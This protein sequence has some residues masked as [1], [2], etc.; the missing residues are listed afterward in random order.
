MDEGK[1]ALELDD[2]ELRADV[3]QEAKYDDAKWRDLPWAIAYYISLIFTLVLGIY[4]IT[5]VDNNDS[6][7]DDTSDAFED[8]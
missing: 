5:Q 7:S 2:V 3:P 1:R 6:G 4:L 8:I